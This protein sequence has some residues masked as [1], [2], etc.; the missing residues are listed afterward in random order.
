MKKDKKQKTKDEIRHEENVK[1]FLEHRKDHKL[2]SRRD[3][4]SHGLISG[5]GLTMAPSLFGLLNS[6][7][8]YGAEGCSEVAAVARKTPIILIDLSGGG[9][10]AGNNV[11][12]GD[13]MGQHSYLGNYRRLGLGDD[14]RPQNTGVNEEFGL[15]FH[16]QSGMLQGM[17]AN[18]T[19]TLRA[20]VEGGVFC[21][22]SD[23]DTGNNP[24]N[25]IY[26]LNKAGANGQLVPTAGTRD[27]RSG[28]RSRV[29]ASSFDP[30]V[31][32]VIIERPQ[33]CTGLV[34][35]GRIGDIFGNNASGEEKARKILKTMEYMSEKRLQMF[36]Q[37]SLPDQVKEVAKCGYDTT[38]FTSGAYSVTGVDPA[39]DA[40][41]TALFNMGDRT[42][43][44]AGSIAKMVLDGF[45]GAGTIE[46]GGYDYHGNGR[47][48]T[49]GRDVEAG[50][51]IGK[52][53]NLAERKQTD[54]MIYVFTDG[55]ISSNRSGNGQLQFTND[56]DDRAATFMLLYRHEAASKADI[57]RNGTGSTAKRQIGH[58][59]SNIAIQRN[60]NQ[61]S[62]NVENLAKAV[63]ANYLALSGEESKLAEVVGNNPFGANI[64][65]YLLF[66]A[67]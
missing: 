42:E 57:I 18:T 61:I 53:L 3:F 27:G 21:A 5:V 7:K 19:E 35:L 23:N 31:S 13:Q 49:D 34:S 33:D 20:K 38:A 60:A 62:N 9:S 40:N 66:K 17:L 2:K 45:A 58:F 24:H 8:A 37:K 39:Q 59:N 51:I 64:E 22:S 46:M 28:G 41:V 48:V 52:I 67:S 36:S 1:H 12:V 11:M 6:H 30:T 50:E 47:N 63:V 54:V 4:L 44:K 29:P 25:P 16:P 32:P 15:K 55:G 43:R 56:D 14:I 10:I 65:D 26:W